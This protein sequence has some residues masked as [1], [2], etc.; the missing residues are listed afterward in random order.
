MHH[1]LVPTLAAAALAGVTFIASGEAAFAAPRVSA[2][3]QSSLGLQRLAQVEGVIPQVLLQ[4]LR[5]GETLLQ[6]AH[7]TYSSAG[8]LAVALLAP[9]KGRLDAV[10]ANGTITTTQENLI[11][12]RLLAGATTL[13]ATPHPL[14]AILMS[15]GVKIRAAVTRSLDAVASACT[16]TPA[17]FISTLRAGGTTVLAACQKTNP[18]ETKAQLTTTIFA[19][20]QARLSSATAVG[21]ITPSQEATLSVQRTHPGRDSEGSHH[22]HPRSRGHQRLRLCVFSTRAADL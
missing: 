16:T 9:A 12:G 19:P 8:A 21:L 7:G 22:S 5:Q 14:Q 17:T 1:R 2:Q 4:D 3:P 15:G 10:A 20:I 11:Y 6:I 13:V 18:Q